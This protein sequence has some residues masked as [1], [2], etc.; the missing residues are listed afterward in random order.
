MRFAYQPS[1]LDTTRQLSRAQAS[2]LLNAIEK[3]QHAIE[4]RQWPQGLGMTH[5]RD[6]YFEFRVD[7]QTRVIYRRSGDLIRYVLSGSHD[8]VRR[9]LKAV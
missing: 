6:D 7:I 4:N 1:F 8:H 5:L 3:F 2:K 9:F